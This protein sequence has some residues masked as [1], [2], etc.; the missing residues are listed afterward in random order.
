MNIMSSAFRIQIFIFSEEQAQD[1]DLFRVG[2][3]VGEYHFFQ[4][5]PGIEGLGR[6][7]QEISF[8]GNKFKGFERLLN[9]SRLLDT[10]FRIGIGVN[11]VL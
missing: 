5:N 7:N 11:A 1:G 8:Q 9:F 6:R 10:D 4:G 2:F 3:G